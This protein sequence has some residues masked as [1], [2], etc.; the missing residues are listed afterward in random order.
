VRDIWIGAKSFE[1]EICGELWNTLWNEHP[2]PQRLEYS[3]EIV[4]R[5]YLLVT[6][7]S[8][9][10]STTGGTLRPGSV[11][12]VHWHPPRSYHPGQCHTVCPPSCLQLS[13]SATPVLRS[14]MS[15]NWPRRA[16]GLIAKKAR[17]LAT[18]WLRNS[19][20]VSVGR[21]GSDTLSENVTMWYLLKWTAGENKQLDDWPNREC[22]P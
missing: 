1:L 10:Q 8:Y 6:I 16:V 5:R 19:Q 14:L 11:D 7:L 3:T 20:W 9:F 21:S 17:R 22:E 4:T 13:L 18:A 12:M 15:L 2:S